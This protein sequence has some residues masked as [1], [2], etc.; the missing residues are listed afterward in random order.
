MCLAGARKRVPKIRQKMRGGRGD[1]GGGEGGRE[2]GSGVEERGAWER[3][4]GNHNLRSLI[5][6]VLT[7][8]IFGC[9]S[10]RAVT[11]HE[12]IPSKYCTG[13]R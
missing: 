6:E 4:K 13:N 9:F 7:L 12:T 11:N 2:R 8:V 3:G 5:G 10:Y 1:E